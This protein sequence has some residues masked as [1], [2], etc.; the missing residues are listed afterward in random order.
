MKP[1]GKD[2]SSF[3]NEKKIVLYVKSELNLI[4]YIRRNN[5]K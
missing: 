4:D 5:W 1:I 2:Y 3:M